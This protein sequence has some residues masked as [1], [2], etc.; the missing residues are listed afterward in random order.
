VQLTPVQKLMLAS[1]KSLLGDFTVKVDREKKIVHTKQDGEVRS[2]TY[3]QLADIAEQLF[4]AA[5]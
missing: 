5:S 3:E 2:Y 4:P 1:A